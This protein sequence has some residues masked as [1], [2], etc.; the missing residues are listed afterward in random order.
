[1]RKLLVLFPRM[2]LAILMVIFIVSIMPGVFGLIIASWI[3]DKF[4]D[5]EHGKE[6]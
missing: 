1:M 4:D 3:N 2:L 6:N 5:F